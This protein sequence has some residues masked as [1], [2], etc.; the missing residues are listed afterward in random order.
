VPATKISFANQDRRLMERVVRATADEFRRFRSFA[1][2]A[3][4]YAQSYRA[5]LER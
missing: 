3:I 2:F 5:L 1:G 4:H